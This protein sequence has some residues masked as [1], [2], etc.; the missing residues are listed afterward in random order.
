MKVKDTNLGRAALDTARRL[1]QAAE[2]QQSHQTGA[3]PAQ[4][5]EAKP[6]DRYDGAGGSMKADAQELQGQLNELRRQFGQ[7]AVDELIAEMPARALKALEALNPELPIKPGESPLQAHRSRVME[8][9]GIEKELDATMGAVRRV[10]EQHTWVGGNYNG[11]LANLEALQTWGSE[12][13]YLE[14]HKDRPLDAQRW[15]KEGKDICQ[16]MNAQLQ[17]AMPGIPEK[18]LLKGPFGE[19]PGTRSVVDYF[20]KTT[21]AGN[22]ESYDS[23]KYL[24]QR[25][26]QFLKDLGNVA[27]SLHP[28]AED[29]A[30]ELAAL[31]TH[32]EK[33]SHPDEK[34]LTA[35]RTEL[36]DANMSIQDLHQEVIGLVSQ[37]NAMATSSE[38]KRETLT[39]THHSATL[40][41]GHSSSHTEHRNRG[42]QVVGSESTGGFQESYSATSG[43]STSQVLNVEARNYD[44]TSMLRL[45]HSS[46]SMESRMKGTTLSG[47]EVGVLLD[48]L[49]AAQRI[50]E[51][52]VAREPN[53]PLVAGLQ[54]WMSESKFHITCEARDGFGNADLANFT[55]AQL[56]P[57][58]IKAGDSGWYASDAAA[59][60]KKE[61][62]DGPP[63]MSRVR[64]LGLNEL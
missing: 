44:F 54:M 53:H 62:Q 49:L 15:L 55:M 21:A 17:A 16:Q 9:I 42:G 28:R 1:E 41:S 58:L 5:T 56:R 47:V 59:V 27:R 29:N 7:G 13:K 38:I 51:V 43:S 4:P 32:I 8:K 31:R 2:T 19:G 18:Y 11:R 26:D 64:S 46:S 37:V 36:M 45:D 22:R 50:Y 24:D 40:S 60:L 6:A 30:R 12:E 3:T 39:G 20:G 61:M 48:R 33:K 63:R 10:I 14:Q 34:G 57:T 35:L 23:G 52:M 25:K